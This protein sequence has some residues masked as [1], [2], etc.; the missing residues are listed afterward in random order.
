MRE[1]YNIHALKQSEHKTALLLVVGNV[2]ELKQT[3]KRFTIQQNL[4]K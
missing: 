3:D 4:I 1:L 2:P